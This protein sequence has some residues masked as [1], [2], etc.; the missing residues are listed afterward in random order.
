M[1]WKFLDFSGCF[2]Y[3]FDIASRVYEVKPSWNDC[4][5][6]LVFDIISEFWI[7]PT[8]LPSYFSKSL[9][10]IQVQTFPHHRTVVFPRVFHWSSSSC[11]QC[12]FRGNQ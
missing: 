3:F 6:S 10:S 11:G 7:W 1:F 5:S 2:Q 4:G 12:T 9:R 8:I